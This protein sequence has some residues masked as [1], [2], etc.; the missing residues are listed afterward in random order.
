MKNPVSRIKNYLSYLRWFTW[1]NKT[2][3]KSFI[4]SI[5]NKLAYRPYLDSGLKIKNTDLFME[6]YISYEAEGQNG[7]K[8][9][10]GAFPNDVLKQIEK[11]LPSCS[12][13]SAETGCGKT[14]ILF[15]NISNDHTVFAV[16]DSDYEN[17]SVKYFMECPLTRP[18]NVTTLFGPTQKTLRTYS[19]HEMYDFVL[20][21]GPHAYPFPD[22]EYLIFYPYIKEG[23]FLILDDVHIPTIGRMAAIIAEDEMFKLV[24]IFR[25]TAIFQRTQE[26]LF[27]PEGDDWYLQ[28]YNKRR[29]PFRFRK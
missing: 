1:S 2:V 13:H 11:I 29:F 10:D 15:S 9:K 21:D 8:H 17:S 20:L 12:Q 4:R 19:S 14:T 28:A 16:D 22:F 6:K 5:F 27:N 25:T 7:I 18:K 3:R 26:K 24:G 23:G